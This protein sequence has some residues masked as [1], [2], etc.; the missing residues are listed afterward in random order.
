VAIW[1]RH[2]DSRFPFIWEAPPQPA[3][4]WHTASDAPATYTADT[5][6]GAWA[7]FLRHEE[8]TDPADLAGIRRR[9]WAI[10]IPDE[11]VASAARPVLPAKVITGGIA[12]YP[13]CRREAA[14]LRAGGAVALLATSAALVP[15]H[16]GGQRV[17]GGLR[18]APPVEGGVLVL[19]GGGWPALNG[20]VAT[21]EG[22]PTERQLSIV[23]HLD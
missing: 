4:R 13:R 20:W 9:V 10:S 12:T 8:I 7:E 21:D 2:G 18:E 23:Q 19:F 15:G 22:R 16:A 17:A 11:V 3:A 6:D 5:P 14:R 1:F